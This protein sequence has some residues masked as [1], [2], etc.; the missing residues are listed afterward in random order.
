[1][2]FKCLDVFLYVDPSPPPALHR[3]IKGLL[4]EKMKGSC[5]TFPATLCHL[6][7]FQSLVCLERMLPH[8]YW[9]TTCCCAPREALHFPDSSKKGRMFG[10]L[11]G[12]FCF[13]SELSLP[14]LLVFFYWFLY[15][16]FQQKES[17]IVTSGGQEDG[18]IMRGWCGVNAQM[19]SMSQVSHVTTG[20][21][22]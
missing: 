5:H 17:A 20:D 9:L 10:P 3:K 4:M 21:R 19:V 22:L 11:D 16:F 8:F 2:W 12:H 15:F 13:V 1:M 7:Y 18:A 14:L 6:I